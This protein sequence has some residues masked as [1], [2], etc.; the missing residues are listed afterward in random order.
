MQP[1]NPLDPPPQIPD[2]PSPD[3]LG[4]SAVPLVPDPPPMGK[5]PDP[6]KHKPATKLATV[7]RPRV[8]PVVQNR[9]ARQ[10]Q[11]PP[12]PVG[13]PLAGIVN[14]A[15][16]DWLTYET[17]FNQGKFRK[18][19]QSRK[20]G[21]YR[22]GMSHVKIW[23]LEEID[24]ASLLEL[25]DAFFPD[26]EPDEIKALSAEAH[27]WQEQG[28]TPPNLASSPD[29]M[30]SARPLHNLYLE[31]FVV[32]PYN[33][34]DNDDES[35]AIGTKATTTGKV[36]LKQL[37]TEW[38]MWNTASRSCVVRLTRVKDKDA[39]WTPYDKVGEWEWLWAAG[40]S[41]TNHL[42]EWSLGQHFRLNNSDKCYSVKTGVCWIGTNPQKG[43]SAGNKD[44]LD[45]NTIDAC[46]RSDYIG[47]ID[48]AV[49]GGGKTDPDLLILKEV[50]S[51]SEDLTGK[52]TTHK[53]GD[54]VQ[55]RDLSALDKSKIYFPPLS[56][57][58]VGKDFKLHHERYAGLKRD[59]VMQFFWRKAY[60]ERVGVAKALLLLRYGL[61]LGSPNAQNFLI[62]MNGDF[63]S[64]GRIVMRD[65]GDA[66]LHREVA[67]AL[68]GPRNEPPPTGLSEAWPQLAAGFTKARNPILNFE[69]T[70]L[71]D[72]K[73]YIMETGVFD[74]SGAYGKQTGVL[75]RFHSFSTLTKG[76]SVATATGSTDSDVRAEGWQLVLEMMADWGRAHNL[77][78]VD[79]IET[80]LGLTVT[81]I[82][83]HTLPDP[84]RYLML[85][86]DEYAK[87]GEYYAED[88]AWEEAAG[89]RVQALIAGPEGQQAIR[90]YRTRGWRPPQKTI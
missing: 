51:I 41:L 9:P 3:P 1:S 8:T 48:K 39:E 45:D 61:Q 23:V 13:D 53:L 88:L 63:T 78:F 54:G 67:W 32:M 4:A 18:T 62:E 22:I 77:A 42:A 57:P 38:D 25:C 44:I 28:G 24:P 12:V 64:T 17:L 35:R 7:T 82:D 10:P 79:T 19:N 40:D 84:A 52:G 81:G 76:A 56:I 27:P 71:L 83:W 80:C 73:G 86:S 43:A 60:A 5:V 11:P 66:Q 30:A 15:A 69:C 34:K 58:F 31:P 46:L 90:D 6:P 55:V 14:N 50:L 68:F 26:S 20:T 74:P 2:P 16:G 21:Q 89:A 47:A 65:I 59:P 33:Y 75:F 36:R 29:V 72:L 85:D 37:T 87:A 70:S 49:G